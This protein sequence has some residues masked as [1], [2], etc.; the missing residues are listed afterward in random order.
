MRTEDE[1]VVAALVR[2]L[3][4]PAAARAKL[5]KP[6]RKNIRLLLNQGKDEKAARKAR[7]A[8]RAA[9]E[10]S[11]LRGVQED[12]EQQRRRRRDE[13]ERRRGG[14]KVDAEER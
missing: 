8:L 7:N 3:G 5:D 2:R 6:T 13:E 9:G 4:Y 1:D 14:Q 12:A 10:P 11:P